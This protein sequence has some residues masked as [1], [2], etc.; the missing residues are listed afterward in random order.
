MT[1]SSIDIQERNTGK[2]LYEY[3]HDAIEQIFVEIEK[4][5]DHI[6]LLFQLPTGGGKTVI[7]SEFARRYIQQTKKKVL[8]LTHRIELCRQTSDML[9][10]FGVKNMIINSKVKELP[11]E[12]DHDCYVAMVETLKNRFRDEVIE[13]EN[14]GLVIID[15]AHYNAFRKLFSYFENQ[16]ILG[17]TA[18]PM[19]SN[20]KYPMK[21]YYDEVIIGHSIKELIERRFL[22]NANFFNYNV[23]LGALKI[24]SNGDYT[25]ES[26]ERLYSNDIMQEK[27]LYAYQE[28]SLGQKTLIFNNGINTSLEVESTFLKAGYNI[29]HLDHSCTEGE[30]RDILKWFKTTPDAI[31]TSVGIL[32]T[33]FDEPT[34]RTI[35]INR[36][37]RSLTLY[38][39]M[40]GRGSR[41]LKDKKEFNV[42][43]LGNNALRF[44]LWQD[45]IDWR[46]IFRNP[47]MYID[48]IKSDEDIERDFVY[49]MPGELKKRFSKTEDLTFD[50]R[51]LHVDAISAGLK[52]KHV[53]DL[54]ID[55]HAQM[56]VDNCDEELD[57]A[58]E[59]ATLLQDDIDFRIRIYSY[60]I[61]KGTDNYLQWLKED[62][63]I[64][65]KIA[66]RKK[67]LE[68]LQS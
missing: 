53:I 25:V 48:N 14:L 40:I 45:W 44:G 61:A 23:K 43:D 34:I 17:V 7:F 13:I 42:I 30:R 35:I 62:Y 29:K 37:T 33:G 24:G 26:S 36:A 8:V 66:I 5:P 57:I 68:M 16:I 55:N 63:L 6:N 4:H 27:L 32:T 52:S 10:E 51:Q 1:Y 31:L 46:D 12:E 15:E 64:K 50:V 54:S 56:C 58:Y 19:S 18:T 20:N 59:L 47:E 39:Q 21:N 38:H 3:Q 60:C 41:V 65:M 49:E 11:E 2:D 22:S 9:T 28:R 67:F